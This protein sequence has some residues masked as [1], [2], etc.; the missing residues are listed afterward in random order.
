MNVLFITNIPSPYRVDFFNELGKHCDLT[1]CFE[2]KTSAERNIKWKGKNAS[3]FKEVFPKLT[4]VGIDKSKGNGIVTFI[5]NNRFD[6]IIISG[7]SSPAVMS[8]IFYCK[9]HHIDYFLE[10][11]GAF[12]KKDKFYLRWLK[13]ILLK[14][15]KVHFTTCDEHKRYLCSLGIPENRIIIYP[16]SSVFKSDIEKNFNVSEEEK[17]TAK[18]KIGAI[19]ANKTILSIGQ[20]IYR[21]GFD[22][23]LKSFKDV[24]PDYELFIVGGLPTSEYLK[25]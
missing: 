24:P 12:Y 19:Q 11:D 9:Q 6:A 20:F 4:P 3:T 21:K 2:R 18:K 1:V 25:S 22:V 13:K 17:I 16:F 23:L 7:Y 5:K 15:A 8:A 10:Y 14:K